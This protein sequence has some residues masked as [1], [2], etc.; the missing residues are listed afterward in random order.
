[1]VP[2]AE[3]VRF[4]GWRTNANREW[5]VWKELGP[6][7]RGRSERPRSLLLSVG[8]NVEEGKP[9]LGHDPV[10][11][12]LS[13]RPRDSGCVCSDAQTFGNHWAII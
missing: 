4:Q 1:M 6:G 9:D 5:V 2:P 12:S 13:V 10:T 7:A 8:G 3:G 11:S